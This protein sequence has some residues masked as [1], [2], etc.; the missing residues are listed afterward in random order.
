MN[1]KL[2]ASKDGILESP[3]AEVDVEVRDIWQPWLKSKCNFVVRYIVPNRTNIIS[4]MENK[5][6]F[7]AEVRI[8]YLIEINLMHVSNETLV[9]FLAR[10][11][12]SQRKRRKDKAFMKMTFRPSLLDRLKG[13]RNQIIRHELDASKLTK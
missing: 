5:K 2:Q 10:V 11:R 8:V 4:I 3:P 7:V 12:K 9:N 6:L 13:K 1:R